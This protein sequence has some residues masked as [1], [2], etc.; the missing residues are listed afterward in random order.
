MI[1]TKLPNSTLKNE[2]QSIGNIVDEDN[3]WDIKILQA[4]KCPEVNVIRLVKSSPFN[5]NLRFYMRSHLRNQ[6]AKYDGVFFLLGQSDQ[7]DKIRFSIC[8]FQIVAFN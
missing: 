3:E 7:T 6:N 5:F 8:W 4:P 2:T 1:A